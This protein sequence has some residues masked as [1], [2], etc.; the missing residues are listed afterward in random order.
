MEGIIPA[1]PDR[2]RAR[3]LE[4]LATLRQRK[5]PSFDHN[6]EAALIVEAYYEVIKDLATAILYCE[7]GKAVDHVALILFLKTK[8]FLPEQDVLLVD[9][10]RRL[11][12]D[13]SYRGV[14]IDPS[15]IKRNEAVIVSLIEKLSR[16]L[17]ERLD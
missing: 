7:G 9:R 5:I 15:F 3:S 14:S 8:R 6:E 10:L 17:Q 11:R 4:R 13:I 2:E 16:I 1:T 12:N